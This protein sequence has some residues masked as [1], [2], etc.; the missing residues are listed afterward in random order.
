MDSNKM[1]LPKINGR[2]QKS[3]SYQNSL[4]MELLQ[5]IAKF[6]EDSGYEFESYE[7]D[8]ILL[9]IIKRNHESY[10]NARFGYDT[11]S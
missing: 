8:N 11:I 9:E 7:I 1:Q 5:T 2:K 3:K 6:E 10:L 4:K